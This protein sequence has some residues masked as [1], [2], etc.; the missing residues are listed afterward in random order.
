MNI[1]GFIIAVYCLFLIDTISQLFSMKNTG[2]RDVYYSHS[3][4]H[5]QFNIFFNH[6]ILGIVFPG[7]ILLC[8]L[9]SFM[10][11]YFAIP[12]SVVLYFVLVGV[13][14][15]ISTLIFDKNIN[16]FKILILHPKIFRLI[17]IVGFCLFIYLR[18]FK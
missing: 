11:W 9:L 5:N 6:N 16:V 3:Y 4:Y 15:K 17:A 13:I 1:F 2:K 10:K 7:V 12:L 8:V 18:L 14:F